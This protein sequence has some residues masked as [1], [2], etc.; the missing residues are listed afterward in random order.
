M[1]GFNHRITTKGSWGKSQ[2]VAV[3]LVLSLLVCFPGSLCADCLISTSKGDVHTKC[4]WIQSDRLYLFEGGE[5]LDLSDVVSITEAPD[6]PAQEQMDRDALRRFRQNV[7]WLEMLEYEIFS[8][9]S[10]SLQ[11]MEDIEALHAAGMNGPEVNKAV[12]ELSSE[13]DNLAR[14]I[15]VLRGYWE[16]M[17][18]PSRSLV[19]SRDIK[20]VQLLSVSSTVFHMQRYL[21]TWDPTYREYALEYAKQART[22]EKSF[23]NRFGH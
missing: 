14:R 4:Y 8:R 3:C 19:L 7:V 21:K 9:Q 2:A 12:K 1:A 13:L 18:I 16:R 17:L 23:Y 6:S 11:R 10:E 22:F 20:F 5:P 15:E